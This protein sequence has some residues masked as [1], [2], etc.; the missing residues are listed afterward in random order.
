MQELNVSTLV[1]ERLIDLDPVGNLTPTL[2]TSWKQLDDTT[3]QLKLREGVKFSNGEDFDADSAKFSIEEMINAPN[4][5]T[6]IGVIAGAD[7]VDKHTLNV[8]TKTPTGVGLLALAMGSYQ[9]PKKYYS[10]VGKDAFGQKPIGTGPYT[11]TDWVKDSQVTLEANPEYWGGPPNI[12]TVIFKNIPEG[13]ARIAAL[14]AGDVDLIV[15]V[16]LDAVERLE[17]NPDL[18]VAKVPGLRTYNLTLSTL[19][20][21]TQSPLT[22]P[23]VRQALMYAVDADTIIDK[24]FAGRATRLAQQ[25]LS[26]VYF[27]YNPN[28]K[29]LPYD[30]AKA[31]QLLAEAGYPNGFEVTFKYPAGRY[32]QDKEVS[33]AIAAQL[34]EV[35]VRTK[36]VVLEPGTFLDQLNKL[37]LN[38]MFFSGSMPP[39]DAHFWLMNY[40]CGFFYSYY[41]NEEYTSLWEKASQT[42]DPDERRQLY[43][44]M[45]DIMIEDPP[46]IP[47]YYVDDHYAFS[48][49]VVGFVPW[50]S[51]HV[52]VQS[53]S[54]K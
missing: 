27:G 11:L 23:K 14:E 5:K 9:F 1:T 39:P 52:D 42:I 12:K 10:E 48:D 37:E 26:P 45:F 38:D 28:L 43:W 4:Y 49:K 17:S 15:D 46:A 33:Q 50:A 40:L 22:D 35:G 54:V 18:N 13:A 21:L 51:G 34:A 2:A 31:K 47:L 29:P 20:K 30:P 32:V 16:P 3:I 41:C 6:F 53:L 36:Q 8:K 7:V 25:P 19:P 44:K 24:I